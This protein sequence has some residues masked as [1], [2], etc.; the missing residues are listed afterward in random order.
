MRIVQACPYAW[1]SPGGVQV[2][3]RQLADHLRSRGHEVV[4]LAPARRSV[5]EDGVRIVGRAVPVPYQGTVAPIA[6]SPTGG[7]AVGRILRDFR[8]H[9]VHAHEPLTP[10]TSMWTTLAHPL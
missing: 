4:V 1:D 7:M 3:V 2:Q 6:P 9:A 8:P 5:R 10:S